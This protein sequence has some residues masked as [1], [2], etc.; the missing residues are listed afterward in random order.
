V[1]DTTLTPPYSF[2]GLTA[3]GLT[4]DQDKSARAMLMRFADLTNLIPFV[5]IVNIGQGG[6][7]TVRQANVEH[8]GNIDAPALAGE[9]SQPDLIDLDVGYSDLSWSSAGFSRS[10]T[11]DQQ[12]ASLPNIR[13]GMDIDQLLAQAPT[14]AYRIISSLVCAIATSCAT[15]R[16]LGHIVIVVMKKLLLFNPESLLLW[17]LLN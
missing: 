7:R 6:S 16:A 3:A 17:L 8:M 15:A 13:A 4:Y 5:T 10:E 1:A 14:A 2:A 11:Y 12:I 9:T